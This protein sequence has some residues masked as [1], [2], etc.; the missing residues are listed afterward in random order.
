MLRFRCGMQAE[1]K[2]GAHRLAQA[3][4]QTGHST[5]PSPLP[6][7]ETIALAAARPAKF[8]S[9]DRCDARRQSAASTGVSPTVPRCSFRLPPGCSEPPAALHPFLPGAVRSR[10]CLPFLAW[11]RRR[12]SWRRHS[13]TGMTEGGM[14]SART[15]CFVGT[16]WLAGSAP[17]FAAAADGTDSVHR[18]AAT[19]P[20]HTDVSSGAANRAYA[21]TRLRGCLPC[22]AALC[23]LAS[24]P[25]T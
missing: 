23:L 3:R 19:D 14:S 4:S 1:G 12:R 6:S 21:P 7:C 11:L 17:F 10:A 18:E 15:I 25:A 9:S 5:V 2:N 13:P 20:R 24:S 22:L 8:L 16:G